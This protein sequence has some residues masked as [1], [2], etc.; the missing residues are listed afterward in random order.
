MRRLA[1]S[2][3]LALLAVIVGTAGVAFA[4]A[5]A[6][7]SGEL[8]AVR[9]AVAQYHS[10]DQA[11]ADGYNAA[12]EPCVESPAGVMGIHAVN[13]PLT[14]DLEIDPLRPEI[15]L[16]VPRA[17]G[18]LRLVGVEYM[19]VALAITPDGPRPWFGTESPE[20]GFL[21]PA[22]SLFGQ[23]F[24]GPMEGHNPEMPWHYDLHVWLF[25]S[26]PSGLFAQFNPNL[27]C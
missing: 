18:S 3:S 19:Q 20:L 23:T 15:M 27:S 2:L 10:Y 5:G 13:R 17:N 7:P 25:E 21:N 1:F 26:N 24:Q 4:G 6:L 22:P 9:A 16:Y 11:L 14:T 8:Q 12:N